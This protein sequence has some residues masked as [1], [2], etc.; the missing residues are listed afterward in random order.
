MNFLKD[1]NRIVYLLSF[2]VVVLIFHISYGL[3][4]IIPTN[5]NWLLSVRH[6]WGQH[7]LGWAFYRNEP[8]TFPLGTIDKLCY[9]VGTNVGYWDSIPLLAFFFKLFSG[10]LPEDFQYIGA[11]LL[12]CHLMMAYYTIKIFNLYKIGLIY[13]LIGVVFIACNP[14]LVYRGL[15]PSLCAHGFI[16]AS[17]YYYLLPLNSLNAKQ[18]NS[19]QVY[20]LL[21]SALI[22]PYICFMIIGFNFILPFRS[23]FYSKVISLQ[24]A[25]IYPV[26]SSILV[27]VL[28]SIFGMVDFSDTV[29][30]EV[31]NS[32][33]LYGFNLNSFFN[34][35][36]Y[37][38]FLPALDQVSPHQY[39]GFLYLGIGV[40]LLTLITTIYFLVTI[41]TSILFFK[42]RKELL[43]LLFLGIA[44]ALFAITNKVTFGNKVL[45]EY[46]IPELILKLGG[47][48]R[49]SGRFFWIAYYLFLILIICV[50]VKYKFSNFIKISVL[51]VLLAIQAYDTKLIY[52]GRDLKFGSY[53]TPLSDEKWIDLVSNFDKIITYPPYNNNLL[54]PMDYQDLCF[55]ALKTNTAISTGYAARENGFKN[56]VF[57][58]SLEADLSKGIIHQ[59]EVI[60]TTPKYLEAFN[61]L[62]H[63]KSVKIQYLDGY[64]VFYSNKKVLKKAIITTEEGKKKTDSISNYY[65]GSTI[66]KTIDRPDFNG[67]IQ[68]NVENLIHQDDVI[69]VEGWAF[70]E[71]STN[72]QD[73]SLY[74][75]ISNEKKT[76]VV[77]S[78]RMPRPDVAKSF[79][80]PNLENSGFSATIFTDEIEKGK[81][82]IGIAIKGKNGDWTYADLDKFQEVG[83][84]EFEK[85]VLTKT[86]PTEGNVIGNI[87]DFEVKPEFI[88]LSGWS[89]FKEQ[90][91]TNNDIKII[92]IGKGKNYLIATQ[93]VKRQDVTK[94]FNN[95]YNYDDAGFSVKMK[96]KDLPKGTYKIGIIVIN[97]KSKIQSV[98]ITERVLNNN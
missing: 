12:F 74:V 20:L 81:Y 87:D 38:T 77:N 15:H 21:I 8:W 26:V 31:A 84:K 40:M 52:L 47:V 6:D 41:K 88:R 69:Q 19:K 16:L 55:I 65:S 91:A 2:L 92:F 53:D 96:R 17:I 43:P 13:T 22:S 29:N 3:E 34:S 83:K 42:G 73:D 24:K 62:L 94:A 44:L 72:N 86:I 27:L 28:W 7:Y 67:K 49:A 25:I 56:Q 80:K 60:V 48:F 33:G 14:V 97:L 57:I 64:Y 71:G 59:D 30:L 10:I 18:I 4:V 46:P 82:D 76:Y 35:S 93:K 89:A 66:L 23:Y 58:D 54:Q 45:F 11:W 68:F 5:I 85:P 95:K 32:Y 70:K 75:T 78:K 98:L 51:L 1:Q 79:G 36:G 50:F 90:H 9:P 63:N 61:V 39:E 37:S